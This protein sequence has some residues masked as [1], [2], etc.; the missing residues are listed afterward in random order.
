MR[1]FFQQQS[2]AS[3]TRVPQGNLTA[4]AAWWSGHSAGATVGKTQ[5]GGTPEWPAL[6]RGVMP[7]QR[8]VTLRH[9][10][11]GNLWHPATAAPSG[12]WGRT[13]LISPSS[14]YPGPEGS[15]V[16]TPRVAVQKGEG[17]GSP[18]T[19]VGRGSWNGTGMPCCRHLKR[20]LSPWP[21]IL[22][23][24]GTS[25]VKNQPLGRRVL[26]CPSA[27]WHSA[28]HRA[29]HREAEKGSGFWIKSFWAVPK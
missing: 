5:P 29:A 3:D 11:H 8:E 15:S 19:A 6:H 22:A 24:S 2:L 7:A 27:L 10:T 1:A 25:G 4:Y 16:N 18:S 17:E 21:D 20:Q 26:M 13:V 12:S 9:I 28:S 23:G 14:L